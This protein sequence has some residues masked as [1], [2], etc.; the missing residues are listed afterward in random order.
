[1]Y[2]AQDFTPLLGTEGFSDEQLNIHFGLYEGYVKNVN[3]AADRLNELQSKQEFT[4]EYAE[5]KRRFGWEFGGMRLHELYFDNMNKEKKEFDIDSK[6][7]A[8]LKE[9]FGTLENGHKDFVATGA[10]RGIGWAVMAYDKIGDRIFHTWVNEH[11][12][13]HLVGCEPLLIMDVFEHAYAVDY[14][15]KRGEYI[16]AF[17]NAVD[18]DVVKGRFDAVAT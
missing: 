8:K 11:D 18:W 6:F 4:P 17:L 14:K 1:M 12:L 10:M 5:I 7:A 9:T 13:G 3:K 16:E 15:M 2:K